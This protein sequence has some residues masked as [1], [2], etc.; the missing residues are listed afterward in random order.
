[1]LKVKGVASNGHSYQQSIVTQ[2][3]C[4]L[5]MFRVTSKLEDYQAGVAD[6]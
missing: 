5:R 4:A 1:M 2:A 3:V 6:F